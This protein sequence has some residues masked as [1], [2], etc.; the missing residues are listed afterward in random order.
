MSVSTTIL[1]RKYLSPV[2]GTPINV[3]YP[4]FSQNHVRVL[5]G[6][7][8]YEAV[9]DTDFTVTLNVVDYSD[10]TITPLASL[11]TKID[12]MI[13]AD[14]TESD[15][16]VV[17]RSMPLTTDMTATLARLREQI[18]LEF[19]RTV[20]RAQE[21][22]DAVNGAIRVPDTEVDNLDM[23]IPPV[24][25]RGTK[26][27]TFAADGTPGVSTLTI[28]ELE[29][30]PASA[31]ASATAAATSA[32]AAASARDAAQLAQTGAETAETNTVAA[33]GAQTLGDHAD[34]NVTGITTGDTL[35]W[36]GTAFLP[37]QVQSVPSGAVFW[38]AANTP[39]SGY[40]EC[41]G[42]ALSRTT[43]ASLFATVGT[44]FGAGDGSTTFNIPDLRGEF[45]RG[46][47][48]ARGVDSGRA[49]GSSQLD[50]MQQITGTWAYGANPAGYGCYGTG[51]VTA[52]PGPTTTEGGANGRVQFTFGFDSANSPGARAGSET[53]GRNIALLPC[54]KY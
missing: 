20:L 33:L 14:A 39:P 29:A 32:T 11:R 10:F 19:D 42:S 25:T 53:R 46:W 2:A 22:N 3:D 48:N 4:A 51:A 52:T 37:G 28:T 27:M 45:I 30:Q 47:D 15:Q 13:A 54:I 9:L 34:V 18:A 6:L 43:Y 40:L 24:A 38:F 31:A 41:D 1:A 12:A 16:I 35:I 50:Q 17:R 8:G 36:S 7:A 23:T 26:V 5:Y 44:T 21:V 49:F